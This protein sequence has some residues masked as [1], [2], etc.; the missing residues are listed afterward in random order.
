LLKKCLLPAIAASVILLIALALPG[1][2]AS[3]APITSTLTISIAPTELIPAQAGF[4]FVS[5]GYPL[6]VSVTLDG[7]PLDTYWTGEGYIATYAFGFDE[8]TGLHPISVSA[9]NPLT[10]ES[11]DQQE[12]ITVVE[13]R[14]P[15]Q[16]V[17]LAFKLLPLLDP[18]LNEAEEAHLDEIYAGRT[19]LAGWD[20]PFEIPAPEAIVTSR[21]GGQRSYNS[22]MWR[23]HHTG[24][25]FRVGMGDPVRATARGR[26]VAAEFLDVRGNVVVLDHGY[27]I[28]SQYAHLSETAVRPGQLVEQGQLIGN[29]GA[30]GR[31]NG[32]HLHFEIVVNGQPIDP[33]RWMAIDP[34]FIPPREVLPDEEDAAGN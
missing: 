4:V 6:D 2:D 11:L 10:G 19:R 27:G 30:T 26:V 34:D 1:R 14:Y 18:A 29:V 15:D 28:F 13:F 8:P 20:W 9:H 12:T 23:S 22:G 32:P 5:G 16:Y 7:E 31:T 24:T 3:A 21:F 25:D 17:A 33:I